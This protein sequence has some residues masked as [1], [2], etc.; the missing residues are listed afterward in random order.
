MTSVLAI[1]QGTTGSTALVVSDAGEVVSRG[2]R[3]FTQHFPQPGWVE[4]DPEEIWSITIEAVA[5][6]L[7][8]APE[9]PAAIGITNQRETVVAWNPRTG[10]PLHRALVWQDRRTAERC[11]EL[12]RELGDEYIKRRT[13]LVWDPYFSATK[14]EWLLKH[15]PE[16]ARAAESGNAVFGTIDSWLAYRLTGG[17]SFVTDHTNASRTLLYN[18]TTGEWDDELLSLFGVPRRSL[19]AIHNSSEIVGTAVVDPVK[20]LP[21]A[22]MVGDQQG[23]LYGQGCWSPGEAKCTYGTGAFILMPLAGGAD[24][25]TR[26][27][28]MLTTVA[29]D[30]RGRRM[31]A[32]EGSVFIAGAAI[33][34]LRD[35][36]ELIADAGETEALAREL[37]DSGGVYFVPALAGL[38][39][40]HWEADA[41]GTIVGITRGTRRA[42]VVR[43]A[44]EAMAYSVRDIAEAVSR[45]SGVRLTRLRVDGGASNNAWLMQF[46][47]DQLR[48]PVERPKF[49]E[50]TGLGAAGLA[51]LA[52]GIWGDPEEFLAGNPY[53]TFMPRD[54]MDDG[55]TGWRRAVDTALHWARNSAVGSR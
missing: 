20:G 19:P 54:L 24:K 30:S 31:P 55:Y 13:G 47:A 2:Y 35:G 11:R 23:A 3:E 16:L 5:E 29:A 18:I 40:P 51:G 1:D 17:K 14:I 4:H 53:K 9:A 33:Q 46:Q 38:G 6:A 28:G 15:A 32:F 21:V 50:T 37:A 48:V 43:A 7:A 42:H 45:D 12:S 8:G 26:V 41:R 44:L 39:A 10:A 25:L 22:G 36:L 34:W 52:A 49:V 27:K